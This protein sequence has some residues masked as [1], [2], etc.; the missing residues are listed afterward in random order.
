LVDIAATSRS[1]ISTLPAVGSMSRVRQRTRVDLPE[2]DRPITTNT[3]PGATSNDTSLTAAMQPV[4][5]SI[6]G[7]LSWASGLPMICSALGPNTF[8]R[9]FTESAGSRSLPGFATAV[10]PGLVVALVVALAEPVPEL[11]VWV[12]GRA[13]FR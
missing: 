12:I 8:H 2:P 13:L 6:S 4:R 5:S 9:F 7:L 11:D 10:E 3:S 1:P